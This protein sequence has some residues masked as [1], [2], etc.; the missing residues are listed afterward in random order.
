M[1][2]AGAIRK[3][4]DAV[5]GGAAIGGV[6]GA[7]APSPP[8]KSRKESPKDYPPAFAQAKLPPP[9]FPQNESLYFSKV[10]REAVAKLNK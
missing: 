2:R 1:T 8:K 10:I 5:I 7:I 9:A 6:T 4:T 3:A